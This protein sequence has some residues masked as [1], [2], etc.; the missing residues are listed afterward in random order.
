MEIITELP[1]I[2]CAYFA[3]I[4]KTTIAI[5]MRPHRNVNCL[6]ELLKI[7]GV[8]NLHID[9][10]TVNYLHLFFFFCSW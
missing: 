6:T 8:K 5:I 1:E 10:W 2:P 9:K 7:V 3:S 4:D